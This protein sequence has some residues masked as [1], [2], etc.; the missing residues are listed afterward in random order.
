V[1]V[2]NLLTKSLPEAIWKIRDSL[3]SAAKSLTFDKSFNFSSWVDRRIQ[4]EAEHELALHHEDC[5]FLCRILTGMPLDGGVLIWPSYWVSY[6]P[7]NS[8]ITRLFIVVFKA[9]Q[10]RKQNELCLV[11]WS[12]FVCSI[13]IS[14]TDA[15]RFN[16]R[17]IMLSRI[18]I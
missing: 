8:A 2:I 13:S 4:L 12:R 7:L 1:T 17:K 14:Y 10:A 15:K 18:Y 6:P 5:S 9:R 11:Q 16:F 3:P